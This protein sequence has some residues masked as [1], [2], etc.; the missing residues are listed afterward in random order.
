LRD[1]GDRDELKAM[2][3][4][5]SDW[6]TES[7]GAVGKKNE[8]NRRRQREAGPGR[9]CAAIAGPHKPDRKSDLA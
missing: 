4:A 7:A 9:Q 1:D 5:G 2:K 3:Q 6:S 8:R